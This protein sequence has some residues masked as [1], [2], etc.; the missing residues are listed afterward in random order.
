MLRM[1]YLTI[2]FLSFI[3]VLPGIVFGQM[4]SLI[5]ADST[6]L[7]ERAV[8][9]QDMHHQRRMQAEEFSRTHGFPVKE[10]FYDGTIVE[11]Q[12]LDQ[13][14]LPVYYRTRNTEAGVAVGA[15]QLHPGGSLGLQLS[16]MGFKAGVWDGGRIHASHPEFSG[17]VT[18]K[19]GSAIESNHATHVAGTIAASGIRPEARGMAFHALVDGYDWNNDRSEMALAAADGLLVSNHSYG[20]DL[21][22]SREEDGSWRWTAHPDSL[23]DYR[24]GFYSSTSRQLDEI[25]YHAPYYTIVWAA[26]NDRSDSGDG[27][28]PPDGPYD[29]IGPESVAKNVLAV[30]SVN[31]L[32]Q[33]YTQPDMVRISAFSSFGPADDGRVKP[34]IVAPGQ[35]LFSTLSGDSYGN[36]TGTSMSAP[37]VS[38]SLLLLQQLYSTLSGGRPM[39]AATLKSLVIHTVNQTGNSPGPDYRF[40]WG[41]LDVE[42]AARLLMNLDSIQYLVAEETLQQDSVYQLA[43][44]ADGSSNIVAT[45]A[46][47]DPPGT[48][49][50]PAMNP[51]DPMLVN[52][53]DMRIIDPSGKEHYPWLLDP[54]QPM[55]L[56]VQD[57]D[58]TVDNV[59]KIFI[60]NPSPGTYFLKISHKG[61]LKDGFQD[62][63]LCLQ[64]QEIP[65]RTTFY[66]VGNDGEWNDPG[67]WS[68]SSG[69]EPATIIP[70]LDDRV[71]FDDHSFSGSSDMYQVVLSEH[72]SCYSIDWKTDIPARLT[73]NGHTL[74]IFSSLLAGNASLAF[75][76][77]GVI[78]FA[79]NHGIGVIELPADSNQNIHLQFDHAFGIW[80]INNDIRVNS[81]E[82]LAGQ[83]HLNNRKVHVNRIIASSESKKVLD[84]SGSEINGLQQF[85]IDTDQ[86]Q[87]IHDGSSLTFT[88]HELTD[89]DSHVVG[90]YLNSGGSMLEL[91]INMSEQ[92]VIE[93]TGYI[94]RFDNHA[95]VAF[96][97][98]HVITH[99]SSGPG[100]T[101]AIKGG[102]TISIQQ[103]FDVV[104]EEGS[105]VSIIGLEP[106]PAWLFNDRNLK[107]CAEYLDV[108]NVSIRGTSIFGAGIHST[109]SGITDGW[110]IDACEDILFADFTVRYACE[111]S[112]AL[113]ENKST[114]QIT[115]LQWVF[116]LDDPLLPGSDLENPT[117]MYNMT[118]PVRVRLTTWDGIDSHSKEEVI[119]VQANLLPTPQ[120]DLDG[121]S[122]VSYVQGFEMQ[123]YIDNEPIPGAHTATYPNTM[124]TPGSYQLMVFDNRCN[125]L[126]DHF[127]YY[128]DHD[129]NF[130]VT[131]L[132][133]IPIPDARILLNGIEHEKGRYLFESMFPGEYAYEISRPG[134]RKVQGREVVLDEGVDIQVRMTKE[135]NQEVHFSAFPNPAYQ[136]VWLESNETFNRVEVYCLAGR[137]VLSDSFESQFIYR[138]D[139]SP[140]NNGIYILHLGLSNEEAVRTKF[141]VMR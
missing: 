17:R 127:E 81:L 37:V 51:R 9:W 44:E 135:V 97:D 110:R 99:L 136:H 76:G 15:S 8:D 79:G 25:A 83:L 3:P 61:T 132:S 45:L 42:K 5:H 90:A 108:H 32:P 41:L 28:R 2:I 122:L 69:G 91:V 16:G 53:L 140:L 114:G 70:G 86:L 115:D 87:V 10:V 89:S 54:D 96:H 43:F 58:N 1:K 129:I 134:F 128:P 30:G 107:F 33:G 24:F 67:N 125:R 64:T 94:N 68:H 119:N 77:P 112:K 27:T 73:F 19:D 39:K 26:G 11:L 4:T 21:G 95:N 60:P 57:Q 102:Q 7:R 78:R 55:A 13:H 74:T 65:F 20:V 82:L 118:G 35:S 29:C 85:D 18:M 6:Y 71:I 23:R 36:R 49:V 22:W 130:T 113:F 120:I 103:S 133:G 104:G 72:V 59:E 14:L 139:V 121:T 50:A 98:D 31:K 124:Q 56:P 117:Y 75:Q 47:T 93:G 80:Q 52:D 126:S 12:Y 101:I 116:D 63:S 38:G 109:L 106:I 137:Q 111:N 141:H 131:N 66:W 88:D 100:T 138:L 40:G 92:L 105:F 48:P 62:F 34:D 46:W 84:I 123:W